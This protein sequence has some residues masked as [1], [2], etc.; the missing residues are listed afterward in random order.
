MTRICR[1]VEAP[2]RRGPTPNW[3]RWWRWR[4]RLRGRSAK[5]A[6]S[7][8]TRPDPTSTSRHCPHA[9]W[10]CRERGP[11]DAIRTDGSTS[12][13]RKGKTHDR[14]RHLECGG[15]TPVRCEQPG[16]GR[17]RRRGRRGYADDP[18]IVQGMAGPLTLQSDPQQLLLRPL[19]VQGLRYQHPRPDPRERERVR[20][21][22]SQGGQGAR[23]P[24]RVR[25]M[26]SRR[27][28]PVWRPRAG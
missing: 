3:L 14:R 12:C 15:Q 6:L 7:T 16:R 10:H 11:H 27:R 26:G 8:G 17:H 9:R 23:R 13:T 19:P 5:A 2:A 4:T 18:R 25:R 22:A 21:L 28:R 24:G 1:R 20:R